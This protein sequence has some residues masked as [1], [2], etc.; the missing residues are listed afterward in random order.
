MMRMRGVTIVMVVANK[1]GL[2]LLS[3]FPFNRSDVVNEKGKG[4]KE[5]SCEGET[6]RRT[7]S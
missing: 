6:G 2:C 7:K 3:L 1:K 4:K 5:K